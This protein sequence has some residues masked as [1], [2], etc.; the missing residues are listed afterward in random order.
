MTSSSR[1][2]SIWS[3]IGDE[4]L[5]SDGQGVLGGVASGE[6]QHKE[7]ELEF[8]GGQTELL[9]VFTG[10]DRGCDRAPDVVG[11]IASFLGGELHGVAKNRGEELGVHTS[12][13]R[14]GLQDA[15]EAVEDAR[16]IL[17]PGCR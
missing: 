7:K 16:P 6:G 14:L 1:Y 4:R 8:V 2:R 3:A 15:I 11:R 9:A 12:P 10:D 17:V 5:Q 13:T